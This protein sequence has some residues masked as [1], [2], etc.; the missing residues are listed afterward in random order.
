MR[1]A[2]ATP[3]RARCWRSKDAL[4]APGPGCAQG[5]VAML[6]TLH[7]CS[8]R[9]RRP[10]RKLAAVPDSVLALSACTMSL[11]HKHEARGTR[12]RRFHSKA[13]GRAIDWYHFAYRDLRIW[14]KHCVAR[15]LVREL[16]PPVPIDSHGFRP[17]S[18]VLNCSLSGRLNPTE[19]V[20][21][22]LTV[23][24]LHCKGS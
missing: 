8:L 3:R 1:V 7:A 19:H 16:P 2:V 18:A 17:L 12:L 22:L 24:S 9:A 11:W 23:A 4:F 6:A 14:P 15:Q 13:G 20:S 5:T 21:S 10:Y